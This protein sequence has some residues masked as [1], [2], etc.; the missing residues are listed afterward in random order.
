MRAQALIDLCTSWP[1]FNPEHI[2]TLF[3]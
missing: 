2:S 3:E 1:K